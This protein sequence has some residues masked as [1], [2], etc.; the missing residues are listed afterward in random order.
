MHR[1]SSL[2]NLDGIAVSHVGTVKSSIF[3]Y[4]H[5]NATVCPLVNKASHLVKNSVPYCS[6][7]R[8]IR[9]DHFRCMYIDRNVALGFR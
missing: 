5:W 6:I 1:S 8:M 9:A 2:Y 7:H 3:H 4:D